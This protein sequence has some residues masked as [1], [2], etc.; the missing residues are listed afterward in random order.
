MRGN[1]AQA[2]RGKTRQ[3]RSDT[4][5][6]RPGLCTPCLVAAGGFSWPMAKIY[7]DVELR[8]P[9]SLTPYPRNG[10]RHPQDH[11]DR[12]AAQIDAHGFDQ[13]IVVDPQ[14]VIIKGH[15]RR[16]AALQLGLP[17][18]P[19]VV[20]DLDEAQARA[21]RLADNQLVSLD[22]DTR[23]LEKELAWL[24]ETDLDLALTGMDDVQIGRLLAGEGERHR[25]DQARVA[26]AQAATADAGPAPGR[27]PQGGAQSPPQGPEPRQRP[28]STRDP[29]G[30]G[31]GDFGQERFSYI[32]IGRRKVPAT[33]EEVEA[34]QESLRDY[35]RDHGTS[36]GFW[37]ALVR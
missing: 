8:D 18:V 21:A 9:A 4:P 34:L 5:T 24:R 35:E 31:G 22:Y 27:H 26:S 2:F 17:T 36:F 23:H 15:G 28:E 33:G 11:L 37:S 3:G 14:G 10:K 30:D 6:L 32:A 12:L 16:L 25:D 1:T 20:A 7:T 19:V 29:D 13:P